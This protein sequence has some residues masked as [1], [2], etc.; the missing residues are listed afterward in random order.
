MFVVCSQISAKI[1]SRNFKRNLD[2]KTDSQKDMQYLNEIRGIIKDS[3]K[4]FSFI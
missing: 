4:M 2:A 3:I 1:E